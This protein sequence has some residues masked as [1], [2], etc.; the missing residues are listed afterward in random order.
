MLNRVMERIHRMNKRTRRV[1]RVLAIL[2]ALAGWWWFSRPQEMRLVEVRL[3]T[4]PKNSRYRF[5]PGTEYLLVT[6]SMPSVAAMRGDGTVYWSIVSP[7]P[8]LPK[9]TYK[10][11]DKIQLSVSDDGRYC[12]AVVPQMRVQKVMLWDQGRLISSSLLPLTFKQ[13]KVNPT[14]IE[15][16]LSQ[17]TLLDNGQIFC[18][19]KTEPTGSMILLDKGKILARGRLP[20]PSGVM[21]DDVSYQVSPDGNVLIVS[22]TEGFTYYRINRVG[23][24]LRCTLVYTAK[25]PPIQTAWGISVPNRPYITS[26]D[27]LVTDSGAIYDAHG[28][29][30]GPSGWRLGQGIRS[31][32]H[33]PTVLQGQYVRSDVLPI[34]NTDSRILDPHTGETWGPA[35]LQPHLLGRTTPDGQY[36]LVDKQPPQI[37]RSIRDWLREQ[38]ILPGS[39]FHRTRKIHLAVYRKPG[40]LCA[41]LPVI[42]NYGSLSIRNH[43]NGQWLELSDLSLSKDGHTLRCMVYDEDE[44]GEPINYIFTYKWR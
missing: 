24:N 18:L 19:A 34:Y 25:E 28:R 33:Q 4:I 11:S 40:R 13:S 2:A 16:I 41:C 42:E 31:S 17:S 37:T 10:Y 15:T 3:I 22:F 6:S 1:L 30:S 9:N 38:N 44:S 26:N 32:A 39:M 7:K 8:M 36:L 14:E 43:K 12:L 21:P 27:F 5:I 20:A 35:Y 23:N 29:V